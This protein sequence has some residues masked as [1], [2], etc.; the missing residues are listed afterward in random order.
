VLRTRV[1]RDRVG[2]RSMAMG[3]AGGARGSA[4]GQGGVAQI[5]GQLSRRAPT[6]RVRSCAMHVISEVSQ[7]KR[8]M[9]NF[10]EFKGQIYPQCQIAL[11]KTKFHVQ[12]LQFKIGP[13]ASTS[14][15]IPY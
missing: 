4:P 10:L 2:L 14:V 7:I 3:A 9:E 1:R 11:Q 13:T 12:S 15:S 6:P 5:V 8:F